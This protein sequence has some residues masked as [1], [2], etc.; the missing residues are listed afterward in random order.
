MRDGFAIAGQPLHTASIFALIIRKLLLGSFPARM[1]VLDP[2][3]LFTESF[4]GAAS[5]VDLSLGL[6]PV[7]LL[8]AD[9][10]AG[11]LSAVQGPLEDEE[12]RLLRDAVRGQGGA[13][14]SLVAE[15]D[16]LAEADPETSKAAS[17]LN[18]RLRRAREDERLSL[19]FGEE[20]EG[21]SADDVV[22]N[23]FRLPDGRPPMTVCQ[24]GHVSPAL[25]PVTARI[26]LRFARTLAKTSGG[27][28]PVLFAAHQVDRLLGEAPEPSAYFAPLCTARTFTA[29]QSGIAAYGA[30]IEGPGTEAASLA[31]RSIGEGECLLLDPLLPWAQAFTP[32][33]LPDGA[34]PGQHQSDQ[35]SGD[36]RTL[37]TRVAA[38]FAGGAA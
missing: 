19:F 14:R 3:D 27:R 29:G 12:R 10:I 26:I 38:A 35:G 32:Q 9:E 22:Q 24:F 17:S 33:G 13:L 25:Q 18:A 36:A 20:A 23:L 6:A 15:I 34:K 16:R 5:V 30:K 7:G 37:L 2:D 31:L 11:I 21:L 1:I 8:A 4:G 28:I